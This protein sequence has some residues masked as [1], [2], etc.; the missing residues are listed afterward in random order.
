MN[1]ERERVYNIY[2]VES[3]MCL[4]V[5]TIFSI[6]VILVAYIQKLTGLDVVTDSTI[7]FI[8]FMALTS[9]QNKNQ[10]NIMRDP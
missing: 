6:V 9:S 2:H 10:R 4:A 1:R 3:K 8:V 5:K 7:S